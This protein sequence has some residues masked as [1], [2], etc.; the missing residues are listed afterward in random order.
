[1][2]VS[3]RCAARSRA[4]RRRRPTPSSVTVSTTSCPSTRSSTSAWSASAWRAMLEIASRSTARS[5]SRIGSGTAVSTG[6]SVRTVGAKPR[7]GTYSFTSLRVSDRREPDCRSWSSKI[8]LRMSLI[9]RSSASTVSSMRSFTARGLGDR[10]DALQL[11]AGGE[12]S[13]DHQ[14]VQVPGDPVPVGDD[15]ELGTVLQSLRAV[16]GECSLVGEGHQQLALL[17]LPGPV[18]LVEQRD[19][20]ARGREVCPQRDHDRLH[21]VESELDRR[22][23]PP[24]V[25]RLGDVGQEALDSVAGG[26]VEGDDRGGV[27][28]RDLD[29][30]R[31]LRSGDGPCAVGDQLERATQVEG[32]LERVREL[33]GGL[34]PLSSAFAEAVGARVLDHEA[35]RG[36][37][38]LDQELVGLGEGQAAV[39]LGQVQVAEDG[40][41]DPH[42]EAEE[43]DH[44]S[45]GSGGS[46]RTAGAHAG[47]RA[48]SPRVRR[49]AAGGC[50]GRAAAH[51]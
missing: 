51:R 23:P 5:W 21:V 33:G 4:G 9:V 29:H 47:R 7:T 46:R 45:D 27:E 42:R 19:Q 11:Q 8:V 14:V 1:M 24:P 26:S 31:G 44:R 36:G 41:P 50:R 28:L 20:H 16:K 3:A 12:E 13:L 34:E 38:R 39:L 17:V 10:P 15:G 49:S 2:R 18:G 37:E 30:G 22:L 43:G 6:P 35:G 25:H 48:G 40:A 32:W